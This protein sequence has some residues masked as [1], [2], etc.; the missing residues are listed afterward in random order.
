VNADASERDG[1]AAA[2]ARLAVLVLR[3]SIHHAMRL[4]PDAYALASA[5]G[6]L[7]TAEALVP[8]FVAAPKPLH[9][10]AVASGGVVKVHAAKKRCSDRTVSS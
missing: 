5:P 6:A 8:A 10:R 1:S 9:G 4:R 2:A 3:G 7:V